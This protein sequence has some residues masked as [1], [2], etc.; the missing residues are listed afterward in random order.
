MEG[1]AKN[2]VFKLMMIA[3][4]PLLF[5]SF[6]PAVSGQMPAVKVHSEVWQE[7]IAGLPQDQG[8]FNRSIRVS[9][10]A[11]LNLPELSR[12]EVADPDT[13]KSKLIPRL[14]KLDKE[15][16]RFVRVSESA[17]K[18]E[19][20]KRLMPA[21]AN[22]EERKLIERLFKAQ[23]IRLPNMRN[24]RLVS[25]LDKRI[26]RLANGMIFNMKALV[27]ERRPYE[28]DLLKAMA[29]YGVKYSARPPDFILDYQLY[30]DGLNEKDQ[31]LF[32]TEIALLG[33]FEIPVVKVAEIV[34]T[35][36]GDE[37]DAQVHAVG[38]M[39]KLITMQLKEFLIQQVKN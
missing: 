32:D 33:Q 15:L 13:L 30:A 1:Q 9:L 22:I 36:P 38:V 7:V 14:Q 18:F 35:E 26:T 11:H 16:S 6:T 19:Q 4:W 8:I 34:V 17:T 39:A 25:F 3:L 24:T 23:K 5:M 28:A 21:M 10:R 20:L 31:W 12:I 27:R 29:S 37:F 2:R